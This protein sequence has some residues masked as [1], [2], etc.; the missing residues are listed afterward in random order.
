MNLRHLR[1]AAIGLGSAA[2]VAC[3]GTTLQVQP[4]AS[5]TAAPAPQP[6]SSA[7]PA[8][9]D[10]DATRWVGAISPEGRPDGL[11]RA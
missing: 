7:A 11:D 2:L 3:G 4:A 1:F 8:T 6:A 9:G 10:C 5:T